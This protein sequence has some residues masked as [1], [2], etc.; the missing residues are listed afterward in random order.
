MPKLLI[1]PIDV[2]IID[3]MGKEFS[4]SGIDP[5]IT[6]RASTPWFTGGPEPK[7]MIVLDITNKSLGNASG[8]GLADVTTKKVFDKMNFES[9]YANVLT[10]TT[11][12]SAKIPIIMESDKLAIQA[13]V[14]ASNLLKSERARIVRIKNTL[15]IQEIQV[16]ESMIED[17]KKE[18]RLTILGKAVDMQF[19]KNDNFEEIGSWN[20]K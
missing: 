14:K 20:N 17:V 7:R 19:D 9:T 12:Q 6:G 1:F 5:N 15:S 13:A 16:S 8:I 18:Q 2:L 3:Q 4:G 10:A 11:I